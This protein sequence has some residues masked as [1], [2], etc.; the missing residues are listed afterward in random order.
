MRTR[1]SAV[2][3]LVY[4]TG[5]CW[6]CQHEPDLSGAPDVSFQNDIR[7]ILSGNCSFA[8]CHDGTGGEPGGLIT[9]EEVMGQVEAG[10]AHKSKIYRVITGRSTEEM[11]PSGY[12]ELNKDDIRLI[13]IWIEQGAKNN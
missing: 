10:N 8:G 13:Y 3:L 6:S 12:P 1:L 7:R 2:I 4:L 9:Y 5:M 11:P